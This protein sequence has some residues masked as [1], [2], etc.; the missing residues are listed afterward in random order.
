MYSPPPLSLLYSPEVS[1]K[2]TRFSLVYIRYLKGFSKKVF[3]SLDCC[4]G[5]CLS[6]TIKELDLSRVFC[7]FYFVMGGFLVREV[8]DEEL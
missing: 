6:I 1:R 7:F 8:L 4:I 3:R 2:G 5:F